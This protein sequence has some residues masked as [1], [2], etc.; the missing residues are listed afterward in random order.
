MTTEEKIIIDPWRLRRQVVEMIARAGSGHLASSLGAADIMAF[1]YNQLID[2]G[3][4][5]LLSAGHLAPLWYA[6]LADKGYFSLD[7]LATFRQ[8]GSPLQGHPQRNP[9]LGITNSAGSL[10]QGISQAVGMAYGLKQTGREGRVVV[11]SSDGEQDEGQVWE[12]YLFAAHYQLDNLL[13]II[14]KNDLQASGQTDQVL[15]TADLREKLTAFNFVV[16]T[17]NGNNEEELS[18]VWQ[19]LVPLPYPKVMIC[20]TVAGKGVPQWEGKRQYH[21]RVPD[22]TE[23][24]VAL[25]E[26]EGKC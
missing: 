26:L 10:G 8:F 12:A 17:A 7:L 13:V 20:Q 14:D 9:S 5:F 25:K 16:G 15:R 1:I 24:T 23:L 6:A 18:H 11:L 21:A 22:Q 3:D 19:Q 4:Y 2:F